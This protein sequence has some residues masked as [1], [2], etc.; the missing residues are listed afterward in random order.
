M[1]NRILLALALLVSVVSVAIGAP[2]TPAQL[3]TDIKTQF[4][5]NGIGGITAGNLR[6]VTTDMVNS[7]S[8][9]GVNTQSSTSYLVQ[10]G[11]Q[12]QVIRFTNSGAVAVSLPQASLNS[13]FISGW[14][15]DVINN[16][17]GTVTI[18][19]SVSTIDGSSSFALASNQGIRVY[20]N[21]TNYFVFRGATNNISGGTIDNAVIGGV[22]PAAGKFTFVG[23]S[24]AGG[25]T[26]VGSTRADALALTAQQNRVTTA[27]S[28]AVGVVLP[29]AATVGAGNAVRVYNDGPS[30]AF[31]V[32]AAGTDTIDGTA[33]STGVSV[34]NAFYCDY[35]ALTAS[36]FA[37][38]RTAFTRST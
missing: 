14:W 25:L 13:Q 8:A 34:T 20:T 21:G 28:S 2:L 18:T 11:D 31:H 7:G 9:I 27:A 12:K 17:S 37:S 36:T 1:L 24:L 4:P 35:L 19:P 15:A 10:N 16:G 26:A 3:V 5:T 38:F 29:A 32:Y 30:N 22:T 23:G 33:G 6:S